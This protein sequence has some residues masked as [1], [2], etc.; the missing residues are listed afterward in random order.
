VPALADAK[1]SPRQGGFADAHT[2]RYYLHNAPPGQASPIDDPETERRMCALMIEE[3][4]RHDA[5]HELF[6]R[7]GLD[8]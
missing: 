1:R 3:M 8:S 2:V 4:R 5:P 6:A 7:F